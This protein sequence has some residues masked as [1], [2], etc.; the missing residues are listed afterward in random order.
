MTPAQRHD[1]ESNL[2]PGVKDGSIIIILATDAPLHPTQLQ[3]L[4]KRATIG[5]SR[6]GGWGSN[7]S[8]DVFLAFSTAT[9]EGVLPRDPPLNWELDVNA[10]GALDVLNNNSVN[11]LFEAAADAVEESV[12]NALCMAEDTLGPAGREC[13]ALP[14]GEVRGLLE[15]HYVV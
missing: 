5:L 11:A 12:Y 1:K 9:A 8:G 6:V 14:L 15:R 2:P 7:T 10:S 4:A 3:R 13:R